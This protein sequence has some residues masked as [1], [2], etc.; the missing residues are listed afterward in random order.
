MLYIILYFIIGKKK[1]F[2]WVKFFFLEIS[3]KLTSIL[4][5]TSSAEINA[6]YHINLMGFCG[7]QLSNNSPQ[8]LMNI[9]Y[10]KHVNYL[11]TET[12]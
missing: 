12:T 7:F 2:T 8:G 4:E 5:L 9:V 11:N 3:Y 1:R 10:P 6:P